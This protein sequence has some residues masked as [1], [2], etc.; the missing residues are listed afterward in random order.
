MGLQSENNLREFHQ[1]RWNE[2]IICEMSTPG[3]RGVIPPKTAPEVEKA[4]GDGVSKIPQALRRANL[5][6]LPEINQMR[7]LRHF[8]RLSQ[9]T[10]GVD[11]AIEISRG[12]CTMKYS[13]KVQ[14]HIAARHP[15][16]TQLHP[17]QD[18]ETLQGVLE[19]YYKLE[20]FLSEISGLECFSLTPPG[21]SPAIFS[22]ACVMRAYHASRGED[23][24]DEIITSVLS[25]PANAA[26]PATAGYKVI[27]LMPTPKAIPTW[28]PCGRRF[29]NARPGFS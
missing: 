9:E 1:A 20:R 27:T 4:V 16:I 18:E 10:L 12:T 3:E 23:W 15:G 25:H 5:P 14:E 24:R 17:F 13:P 19:I 11:L 28:R 8:M 29:P 7:V 22:N 6:N 26:A 21:G 2:P